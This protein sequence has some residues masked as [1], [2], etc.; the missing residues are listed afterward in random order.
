VTVLPSVGA[1]TA[2][3]LGIVHSTGFRYP[4][5]VVTSYNEARMTPLTTPWQTTL[6]ARLEVSPQASTYRYWDYWGTQVTAFDV[7]PRHDRL[8]VT[9]RSVV[10]TFSPPAPTGSDVGWEALRAP[11]T[12]DRYAELL[13]PTPRTEP[14]EPAMEQVRERVAGVAPAATGERVCAWVSEVMDYVP[15]ATGVHTSAEEAWAVRKGVCQDMAH[16]AVGVL[17]RLG[18]PA[19]YVS[20]YLLPRAD[21]P[22]GETVRGES[23]AWVEWWAGDWQAWDPTNGRRVGPDHVLVGRGRDYDD[24]PPLRGVYAGPGGGELFVSV[25]FT[26]LA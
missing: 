2:A 15:G 26:R 12:L 4:G 17:R 22:V 6:E 16:V 3:R 9:A 19:R 11:A 23:H 13:A 7:R 18:V 8:T 10:E 1:G 14:G 25:E 21:L 5:P 24:V 20:G